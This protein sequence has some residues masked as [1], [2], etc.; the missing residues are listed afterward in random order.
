MPVGPFKLFFSILSTLVVVLATV[1]LVGNAST[2]QSSITPAVATSSTLAV[3]ENTSN[4]IVV[5][6][7][8]AAESEAPPTIKA[9]QLVPP[10]PKK[11]AK[12]VPVQ[13]SQSPAPPTPSGVGAPTGSVGAV[14]TAAATQLAVAGLDVSASAL[15]GVLVNILCY[16]PSGSGVHSISG[17]GI[18]VDPK[19][20]ILTN[21]H[22]AQYFLLADRGVSC[23]VRS[24]SPATDQYAAGLIY[25]PPAWITANA[26][27]LTQANPSGT[28]EYD[29]AFIGV[30]KSLT[31]TALPSSFPSMPLAT[32]PLVTG[33]PI[34]IG[35]YGAQFL[36]SSQ[37][38]SNLFPTVVFGSVKNIFTFATSTIDVLALGGSAAAQEG[39]SGGGVANALGEIA[40]TITTST[41]EGATDTRQLNAITASYIRSAFLAETG[42]SLDTLLSMPVEAAIASFAST[43]TGLRATL[44]SHLP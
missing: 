14:S 32:L 30:T 27:L 5:S 2:Q 12:P 13:T 37:I 20:I 21:A 33:V 18:F 26:S 4:S 15:R 22:I 3:V 44:N 35:S 36:E 11:A 29:F 9:E 31:A 34:V 1:F 6:E 43:A 41:M 38:Q 16:A 17:S 40:G 24:G 7:P 25:I 23:K 28:G 10:A 19:G 42:L 39:S 8:P